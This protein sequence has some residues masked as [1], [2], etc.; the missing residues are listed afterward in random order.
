MTC[1]YAWLAEVRFHPSFA[2]VPP[3]MAD[4]EAT[5]GRRV[6]GHARASRGSHRPA[7]G[8]HPDQPRTGWD[9][10]CDVMDDGLNKTSRAIPSSL[11]WVSG[12]V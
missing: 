2:A 9:L 10:L 8:V 4:A 3:V 11:R 6:D 1:R 7:Y 5:A 12:I